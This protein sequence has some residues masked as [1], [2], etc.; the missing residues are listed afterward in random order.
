[1]SATHY[2]VREFAGKDGVVFRS[3]Q[4][5]DATSWPNLSNLLRSR[6]LRDKTATEVLREQTQAR[7]IRAKG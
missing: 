6:Y 3:G 4:Q 5:V 1:M 7:P 2:V